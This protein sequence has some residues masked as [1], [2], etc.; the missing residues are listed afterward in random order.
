MDAALAQVAR[1]TDGLAAARQAAGALTIRRPELKIRVVGGQIEVKPLDPDSPSRRLIGDVDF[2]I[3]E[4][5]EL[6]IW[7]G[8]HLTDLL[9]T[10]LV[11]ASGRGPAA[12]G[13]G[14]RFINAWSSHTLPFRPFLIHTD[15]ERTSGASATRLVFGAQPPVYSPCSA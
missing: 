15:A 3:T 2:T 10:V 13:P 8:V 9:P 7:L 12:E 4:L 1:V 6:S 11:E 14:R 5:I